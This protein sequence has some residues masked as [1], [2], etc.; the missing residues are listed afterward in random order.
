MDGQLIEEKEI[1]DN[2]KHK[3]YI[4]YDES[5]LL[6][7][8]NYMDGKYTIQK[9]FKNNYIGLEDYETTRKN[10]NEE[11]KI[12]DYFNLNKKEEINADKKL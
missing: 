6:L 11:E 12:L 4:T 3:T 2:L 7:E 1:T 10:F 8:I 5:K 9:T